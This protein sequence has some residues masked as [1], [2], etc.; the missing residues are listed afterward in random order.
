M[1]QNSS[2]KL[3]V[4]DH[5]TPL[6]MPHFPAPLHAVIWRNWELA[7]VERLAKVLRAT[8]EQ[9]EEI[10]RSMGLPE[11]QPISPEVWRRS[12]ITVIRR[13][14]HLLPYEQLLELLGWTAD[15]M[16]YTLREDD[17]LYIKLGS[18]KP[19]CPP[20]RYAPPDEAARQKAAW[21]RDCI[22]DHFG[23]V[24]T[25]A[26]EPRFAF[27]QDLSARV[28]KPSPPPASPSEDGFNIR[29]LYSYFGLYGDPL[30]NPELDPYPDG[31][32]ARLAQLGVN[33]V[34]LQGV[35]H[36]LA[37]WS[38][39]PE[40]SQDFEWRLTNLRHL[41]ERA[42]RHGVGVYLYLNEPR[43]MPLSFFEDHSDWRGIAEG[44]YAALCTSV[45]TVQVFLRDGLTHVFDHVPDL[46]GVFTISASENLTNCW[47]HGRGVDCPR[48]GQRSPADVIAEVNRLV[49][50]G[51]HRAQPQAQV[52]V[53]DWGWADEWA[54]DAI[55]LLPR[56]VSL[57]SVSEWSLPIIRGGIASTV[58][59]YSISSVGPGPRATTHWSVARQAGL[60]TVAKVQLNSTWE[61]SAVPYLPCMDL[62]AEHLENLTR[63]EVNRLML[64]WTVGGYPSPNLALAARYCGQ[65]DVTSED[66]LDAVAEE[67]YGSVLAPVVRQSW[68]RCSEAFREFPFHVGV[69]YKAPVQVGP[70]NLLFDAPTGYQATMSGLPY[71]DLVGWRAIYP[72]EVFITQME[73]VATGWREALEILRAAAPPV[74]SQSHSESEIV[75]RLD[76]TPLHSMPDYKRVAF[77][78][79]L[80]VMEAAYLHF[81]SVAQQSRFVLARNCLAEATH[82]AKREE[83]R[84]T[85]GH[86][87]ID[88]IA[89]ARQLFDLVT[90]DSRIG[91]ESSNQYYYTRLDLAEK[92]LNCLDLR[93]RW[94]AE[95][96]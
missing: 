4:G 65:T 8:P 41:V 3:P 18:H 22:K 58:G 39:H 2:L 47:S 57:M 71:D 54:T 67:F 48:C 91:F 38:P 46:A 37:P 64:S 23:D 34:W 12:Y 72:P 25:V 95:H 21:I 19:K 66:N 32:L 31:Y 44:E 50:E 45:P 6:A 14:W 1:S 15:E 61:L 24:W 83:L 43:A 42:R 92:V 77:D 96:G 69:V 7:P 40:L 81:H 60:P 89:A 68:T 33:G 78:D 82:L 86:L 79:L 56:D 73:K 49:A 52:I 30:L 11:S 87:L 80:R 20:V 74:R 5:P 90:A 62:V 13:N 94:L 27:V 63:A 26:P 88:E 28:A 16:A 59:E 17:F 29:F 70:A 84:A 35:L 76:D 53:W 51:V 9:V 75:C 36:K 85:L 93:Q 55:D 10:G